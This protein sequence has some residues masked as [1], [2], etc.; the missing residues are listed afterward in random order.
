MNAPLRLFLMTRRFGNDWKIFVSQKLEDTVEEW[1]Q[2]LH[3]EKVVG[4]LHVGFGRPPTR[5]FNAIADRNE[6]RLLIT[7]GARYV[8][9]KSYSCSNS[10][11]ADVDGLPL[12]LALEGWG[13]SIE[14]PTIGAS[15]H[16]GEGNKG[17]YSS[18]GEP[19]QVLTGWVARF[20]TVAPEFDEVLRQARIYDEESY[21]KNEAQLDNT[22]RT[23]LGQFRYDFLIRDPSDPTDIVRCAP[24][25]LRSEELETL[26]LTVRLSNVFNKYE[27]RLVSDLNQY[28]AQTL[29]HLSNFGRRSGR[30]LV[31]ALL[32]GLKRGPLDHMSLTNSS[33]ADTAISKDAN[34]AV[35]DAVTVTTANS[36]G[37]I[38]SLLK[39]LNEIDERDREVLLGRM[40][41]YSSPRTLEDLAGDYGITRERIRQIE[42][43]A[44]ERIIAQE[45][46]DDVMRH[47]LNTILDARDEP[48]PLFGLEVIDD[49]FRGTAEKQDALTYLVDAICEK[50]VHVVK[51]GTIRYL[52]RIEQ[53]TWD[54]KLR[55]ARQLLE[56]AVGLNWSEVECRN[57]LDNLL[58]KSA[59]EMAP[60]LWTEAS[61]LC[62]FS[63]PAEGRILTAYGR[64]L[65]QLVQVVLEDSPKPL[66]T[67]EIAHLASELSGKQIEEPQIRNA[68]ANVGFLLGRGTYGLRKHVPLSDAEIESVAE[69]ASEI[70][71]ENADGR[72]WHTSE[73]VPDLQELDASLNERLDKYGLNVALQMKSQLKYLGRLVWAAPEANEQQ[74]V[75][76]KEAVVG[77][78]EAAQKPLT[79]REINER[80]SEFRGLN[81][82]VQ[83]WK[84]D[85]V[86][87]VRPG[88][89][90]LN[91][92]DVPVKR[93]EQPVL[94][95]D[96]VTALR[97]KG[98]GIHADEIS[99]YV[100]FPP[101]MD[102]EAVFSIA[103]LDDRVAVASGR[104]VYLKEWGEPRRLT[105]QG[106]LRKLVHQVAGPMFIEDI[107]RSV[108]FM[109][110][111]EIDKATVSHALT[112][113]GAEYLGDGIWK[114]Q[115]T[116]PSDEDGH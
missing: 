77:I 21:L 58:P 42:K 47:R 66:H 113:M 34:A 13:Y 97:Q 84:S 10:M 78:L 101:I 94:I 105:V 57:I 83:I 28:N 51:V 86:L 95:E 4:I 106:A 71:T 40:G 73:L 20:V 63:G 89:W 48:L 38:A 93:D 75:D 115:D 43:R 45:L 12:F 114:L 109:T 116:D 55:E 37:L 92:R 29:H 50:R 80:L 32:R 41:F 104:F 24:P 108:D 98:S 64:G 6:G 91:D 3:D 102:P 61:R 19:E 22:V 59:S 49:W 16:F 5:E 14:D 35:G 110:E 103:T 18:D 36:L 25:W 60:L 23:A 69:K 27:I 112:N 85:I 54:K 67:S 107:K 11:V 46:W 72:Q 8:L 90:G 52:T 100:S 39:T 62:H 65:E 26:Q 70:V 17:D 30:D 2:Q 79:S 7:Q 9:P 33:G 96:V 53:E 68:T 88:L 31:E 87:R 56:S 1:L 82:V 15:P 74:R 99:D 44:L 76:I 81:G 111:R